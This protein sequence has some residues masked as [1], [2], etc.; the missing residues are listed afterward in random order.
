MR[1]K[2]REGEE[3]RK[4]R[5]RERSPYPR[6]T[7]RRL[8]SGDKQETD[9][10]S[11]SSEEQLSLREAERDLRKAQ[12]RVEKEKKKISKQR[13]IRTVNSRIFDDEELESEIARL[14]RETVRKSEESGA[15]R[16]VRRVKKGSTVSCSSSLR[17]DSSINGRPLVK[18]SSKQLS[19]EKMN[20]AD[21]DWSKLCEFIEQMKFET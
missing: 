2:N 21:Q 20:K 5:G 19:S 14:E 15:R 7:I 17:D 9:R 10:D 12:E 16:R 18:G 8:A 1:S 6:E 4:K 3:E 11:D 13:R